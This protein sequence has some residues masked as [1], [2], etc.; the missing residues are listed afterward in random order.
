MAAFSAILVRLQARRWVLRAFSKQIG[1][2]LDAKMVAKVVPERHA[3]VKP[4]MTSIF[5]YFL[6]DFETEMHVFKRTIRVF[7]ECDMKCVSA[8]RFS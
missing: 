8:L 3:K 6:A 4:F 5:I 1:L 7:I 2:P